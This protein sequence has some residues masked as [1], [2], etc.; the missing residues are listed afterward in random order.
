[1]G[2]EEGWLVSGLGLVGQSSI[3]W[4]IDWPRCGRPPANPLTDS[5]PNPSTSASW[6]I[7]TCLARTNSCFHRIP[8]SRKA[9]GWRND[10][11]WGLDSRSL[12]L[13]LARRSRC[14]HTSIPVHSTPMPI[15]PSQASLTVCHAPTPVISYRHPSLR[16]PPRSCDPGLNLSSGATVTTHTRSRSSRG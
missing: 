10:G 7:R 6:P 12:F 9:R 3:V 1:M 4:L 14:P 2:T 15:N 8:Y 16:S 13:S 5:C 11:P